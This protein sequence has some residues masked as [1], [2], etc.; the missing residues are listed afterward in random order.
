MDNSS[1]PT[2]AALYRSYPP[3]YKEH[4]F[5]TSAEFPASN[6]SHYSAP[7]STDPTTP[8][9]ALIAPQ[10]SNSHSFY[11]PS[12]CSPKS[13]P[14]QTACPTQVLYSQHFEQT[15]P[16][17]HSLPSP[18]Q[19]PLHTIPNHFQQCNNPAHLLTTSTSEP[20]NDDPW[21]TP[22][23]S[24]LNATTNQPVTQICRSRAD[25]YSKVD[26]GEPNN[27]TDLPLPQDIS[28]DQ[29]ALLIE[30]AL[31][32]D[33]IS[34]SQNQDR[35]VKP[36]DELYPFVDLSSHTPCP[37]LLPAQASPE[38]SQPSPPPSPAP[39]PTPFENL[40]QYAP[41]LNIPNDNSHATNHIDL[42][43]LDAG[44][45]QRNFAYE[46]KKELGNQNQSTSLLQGVDSS[47]QVHAS[48]V[49]HLP[50]DQLSEDH[51]SGDNAQLSSA[52]TVSKDIPKSPSTTSEGMK[53][54]NTLGSACFAGFY[55]VTLTRTLIRNHTVPLT[56]RR[57]FL[58][59]QVHFGFT[60]RDQRDGKYRHVHTV[61]IPY[62]ALNTAGEW[63]RVRLG[64][65]T[66][67][68]TFKQIKD[69]L[70]R[71]LTNAWGNNNWAPLVQRFQTDFAD[72]FR[73]SVEDALRSEAVVGRGFG[74]PRQ[75]FHLLNC[76]KG[77][78]D[79]RHDVDGA[80]SARESL[81]WV[82][83]ELGLNVTGSDVPV[84]Q[85]RD[86]IFPL[87]KHHC[88]YVRE[89]S[90][91]N[92]CPFYSGG[93]FKKIM[94]HRHL[95][96]VDG[97]LS[98]YHVKD[99]FEGLEEVIKVWSNPTGMCV[100]EAKCAAGLRY[101]VDKSFQ[102]GIRSY[103]KAKF[104]EAAPHTALE[105]TSMER[106]LHRQ[107]QSVVWLKTKKFAKCRRA[108]R[109]I[110]IRARAIGNL[111]IPEALSAQD[112]GFSC[113]GNLLNSPASRKRKRQEREQDHEGDNCALDVER[114]AGLDLPTPR[115]QKRKHAHLSLKRKEAMEQQVKEYLEA[116]Q[117]DCRRQQ[118]LL[119]EAKEHGQNCNCQRVALDDVATSSRYLTS[120]ST[121]VA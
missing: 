89:H 70:Q 22:T 92:C 26:M 77:A 88:A 110:E 28:I 37:T 102:S 11:H 76:H 19:Y 106:H 55:L 56:V 33:I 8:N 98:A 12:Y 86:D 105:L 13:E 50:L 117:A 78:P 18:L 73:L 67:S 99:L 81:K 114:S 36:E 57:A 96:D 3:R 97:C 27:H 66:K 112:G 16:L 41:T 51:L 60:I 44:L 1:L 111:P 71:C 121:P 5:V 90:I 65:S 31:N 61:Q 116:I 118:E 100:R 115:E 63:L 101:N 38:L 108:L 40:G 113:S 84:A 91:A 32:E 68:C 6:I 43:E 75:Y 52:H 120:N 21:F 64:I 69:T 103:A 85:F 25:H 20:T 34:P 83:S 4:P 79:I 17:T 35:F 46:M 47:R 14:F 54:I 45:S 72:D 82:L 2:Y 109:E 49:P 58:A 119:D 95:Y 30:Q 9:D 7:P 39:Q 42:S 107:V 10:I 23:T 15:P 53:P 59:P 24:S 104:L 74:T 48:C 62:D 94:T 93:Y 29:H 80:I 87:W